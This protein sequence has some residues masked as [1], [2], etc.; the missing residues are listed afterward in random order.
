MGTNRL[1]E[2]ATSL[3]SGNWTGAAV[4]ITDGDDHLIEH[5]I[6]TVSGGLDQSGLTEGVE[7]FWIT[8]GCTSGVLGGGS[9]GPLI[10]DADSTAD[11]F[12]RQEG[13][14]DFYLQA[15]GD[16]SLVNNLDVAAGRTYLM[17]GTFATTYVRGGVLSSNG[18]S[19]MT[20]VY[21]LGGSGKIE[22][23]ATK[24]TTLY[25]L[26]GQWTIER[27]ATTMVVSDKAR[28]I[29]DPPD[30]TDH[31][32]TTLNTYGG[33][34]DWRSGNILTV[35]GYDGVID[36]TNARTAVDVGGTA[37]T[38]YGATLKAGGSADVSNVT[39]PAALSRSLDQGIP[40]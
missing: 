29:Y 37:A 34:L 9:A 3:A 24:I 26:G 2:G 19:V 13:A 10:I 20:T 33:V 22:Y 15:G 32:G 30:G 28:V 31:T 8:P 39:Y 14:I 18:S 25:V 11:A 23:N 6:G 1:N 38:L 27:A 40:L 35:N 5:P 21:L 36:L 4:A 7:S 16:N 17:G 12:I